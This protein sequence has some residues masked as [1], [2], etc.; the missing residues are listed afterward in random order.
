MDTGNPEEDEGDSGSDPMTVSPPDHLA[1]LQL[2]LDAAD[3][4]DRERWAVSGCL[5]T[6]CRL[7]PGEMMPVL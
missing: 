5:A 3:E 4:I 1:N 6:V 2:L 7:V